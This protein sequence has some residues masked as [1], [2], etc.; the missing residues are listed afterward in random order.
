FEVEWLGTSHATVND[1]EKIDDAMWVSTLEGVYRKDAQGQTKLPSLDAGNKEAHAIFRQSDGTIWVGTETIVQRWDGATHSFEFPPMTLFENKK[2]AW[3]ATRISDIT[4][5]DYKGDEYLLFNAYGH[6]CITYSPAD[7]KWALGYANNG[8]TDNL[9]K[10]FYTDSRGN[11]WM[12]GTLRGLMKYIEPVPGPTGSPVI[13]WANREEKLCTFN[14]KC[15]PYLQPGISPDVTAMLEDKPGSFWVATLGSGLL[16][17]ESEKD[18][19]WFSTIKD[20]PLSVKSL[21][22]D[23]RGVLWMNASGGL[24]SYNPKSSEWKRFDEDDGIPAAGLSA[25]IYANDEG[26]MFVGGNGFYLSFD[27]LVSLP[28]NEQP[29][30][31]ITHLDV[32]N[33]FVDSLLQVTNPEIPY[34][35][36]F[37]TFHFTSLCFNDAANCTFRYKLEGLED[38]WN[39]NGTL[40]FVRFNRLPPGKYTFKVVARNSSGLEDSGEAV[41]SFT[42]LPPFYLEWWFLGLTLFVIGMI[43]FVLIRNR[44]AQRKKLE[45]IRNKIARDLHDDVGSALGSIS[46]YSESAKKALRENNPDATSMVLE[47]MGSTSREMIENMHDIVW[48][49]NPEHDAMEHV[50]ERMR[51][52]AADIASAND[53]KLQF[54]ADETLGQVKLTMTERK[55][56]FLIFKESLYNAV[57]YSGCSTLMVSIAAGPPHNSGHDRRTWRVCLCVRDDGKGFDVE[58]RLGKGNGLTNMTVRAQEIHAAI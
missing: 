11:L 43:A 38:D 55:N 56:L 3:G 57:K 49:V 16:Y 33:K 35:Q 26:S 25:A 5:I 22:R 15:E 42:I 23:K 58:K 4:T 29:K 14:Y 6:G 46:I 21:E 17:F 40:N 45:G 44:T 30:T 7:G 36:N 34:S 13:P 2:S 28:N 1:F 10:Q 19:L 52:H 51:I 9:I 24:Y 12:L 37:L 54:E 50:I 47:K 27:P 20:T 53:L 48:A 41:F 18:S 8:A 32:M 39:E 31:L